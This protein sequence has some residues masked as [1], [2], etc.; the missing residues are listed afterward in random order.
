MYGPSV[1]VRQF[2]CRHLKST[3]ALLTFIIPSRWTL[4]ISR[5]AVA[6]MCSNCWRCGHT[7]RSEN[8]SFRLRGKKRPS[9]ICPG[10][11]IQRSSERETAS[12]AASVDTEL[13]AAEASKT[14]VWETGSGVLFAVCRLCSAGT[15][16]EKDS[17]PLASTGRT[18]CTPVGSAAV[19]SATSTNDNALGPPG[20]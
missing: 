1:I 6:A 18:G 5:S 20:G 9:E 15:G 14:N 13:S 3:P 19:E 4:D 8:Q 2:K 17:Q 16:V 11:A 10:G 7:L 12:I